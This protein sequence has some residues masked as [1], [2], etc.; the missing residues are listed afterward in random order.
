MALFRVLATGLLA[1]VAAACADLDQ[2]DRFG[3][4]YDE[5]LQRS[6]FRSGYPLG[7]HTYASSYQADGIQIEYFTEDGR[8]FLWY[9]SG[10]T[11]IPGKWRRTE[12]GSLCFSY[13]AM[14]YSRITKESSDAGEEKCY[15]RGR[16]ERVLI[17][18]SAGDVFDLE[19][20]TVPGFDLTNCRLPDPM[21]LMTVSWSCEPRDGPSPIVAFTRDIM[22]RLDE[23]H[24]LCLLASF[25]EHGDLD[26]DPEAIARELE[27]SCKAAGFDF[28]ATDALLMAIVAREMVNTGREA[29]GS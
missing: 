7:G 5:N 11:A 4:Q 10:T 21:K 23:P 29:G 17:S 16:L 13:D 3:N 25:G 14:F 20:G 8:T 9:P 19:E 18:R 6:A 27:S 12:E 1:M 28:P 15:P 22:D 2:P 26:S 24:F